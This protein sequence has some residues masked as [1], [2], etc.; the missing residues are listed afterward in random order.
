MSRPRS[1]A[2]R[3]AL[4][5]LQV[6]LPPSERDPIIGDLLE[7][8][9]ARAES[10]GPDAAARWL[11]REALRLIRAL[12]TVRLNP[13]PRPWRRERR[14][15]DRLMAALLQDV[16]YAVRFLVRTPGFA[17]VAAVT[18]ALGIGATTAIFSVVNAVLLRPL[19]YAGADRLVRVS[20]HIPGRPLAPPGSDSDPVV[21]TSDTFD[22]WRESATTLDGLGGYAARAFTLTGRGDPVRLRGT[23]VSATLLSMLGARPVVGRLFRPGEDVRGNDRYA[24]LSY[25]LWDRRFGH[26]AEIAGK[27][28]TLDGNSYTVV[29]VQPRSF[30]FPDHETQLW[31]PMVTRIAPSRPGVHMTLIFTAI[32]MLKRGVTLEQ[33]EAEGATMSQRVQARLPPGV[34]APAANGKASIRLIPLQQQMVA[35]VRTALL[36]LLGAVGFVLL[37]ACANVANLL[38]ARGTARRRELAV[39]AAVGATRARLGRQLLTES[40]LVGAAGGA[41]G[42]AVAF[43]LVRVLPA[44]VPENFPR[45]EEVGVDL[46]VLGFAVGVSVLTGLV[47]GLA[48]ALRGSRVD[49]LWTLN[50]A[51]APRSGGFALARGDRLRALLVVGEIALSLVLLVGAGL[52]AKSFVTLVSV[53]PGYDPAN[54]LTAQINLPRTRYLGLEKQR[55]F[56]QPLLDRLEALRGVDAAGMTTDLP[57]VSLEVAYS[58]DIEGVEPSSTRDEPRAAVHIVTPGYVRAMGLRLVEGR[59]LTGEDREGTPPVV[60]VNH[61]LARRYLGGTALGH[62]LHDVFGNEAAQVVGVVGDVRHAGLDREPRPEIYVALAQ[63]PAHQFDYIALDASLVVRTEGDPLAVV[64][65]VRQ[66][67][68]GIDPN[69]P[70]DN[71]MTMDQRLSASVAEP[72][73]YALLL[74]LFAALAL[75][76]AVVGIYGVLSYNVSQR[77]REIGVRMALGAERRDILRLVVRQGLLLTL[78]GVALGLAGALGVTRFLATLLFGVTATDPATYVGLSLLLVVVA[79]L[80]CWI[81]ARRATRVDP[82]T[83]LRYE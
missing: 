79:F 65:A 21:M 42:V 34:K 19:P 53:K 46:R 1:F 41:L 30:F 18:L 15:G 49:V 73:C 7:A 32:A 69:L 52:L 17:A 25:G 59:D 71:V 56:W 20:E 22:A 82:M 67:V 74:G 37:I 23:A 4:R 47:F 9:A 83:A 63:V 60:L 26:D 3:L 48:P 24:V 27:A 78:V 58:F 64:P 43:A 44:V 50:E 62:R 38:L 80:A 10:A 55:A 45:I 6:C 12:L 33:A 57:L 66:A 11:N 29:G 31:T 36:V 77:H 35:G 70:L 16:R 2:T 8:H 54:V 13:A 40:V 61:A 75:L 72:R 39:R 81:P 76:L 5:A 51:G 68:L 28:V 14:K